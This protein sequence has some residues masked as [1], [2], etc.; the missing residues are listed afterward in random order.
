MDQQMKS[1]LWQKQLC[2]SLFECTL[3]VVGVGNIG[4]AVLRRAKGFGIGLYGNDIVEIDPAYLEEV[5]VRMTSLEDLLRHSDFISINCDLNPTSFHLINRDSLSH[6]REGAILINTARGPIVDEDALIEAL[7]LGRLMGAALDV[8]EQEPLPLSSPLL[9]MEN[10]LL[11]PHNSNSS[12]AA[13]EYVHQNTIRNLFNGLGI[14]TD[15]FSR[16]SKLP[17]LP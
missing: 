12:P 4:K 15:A 8:F 10:V 3:G 13:W 1:G 2:R 14:A 11:A 9:K 7:R 5:G 17:W 16:L 6:A